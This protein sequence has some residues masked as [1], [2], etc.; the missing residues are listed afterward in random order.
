MSKLKIRAGIKKILRILLF[1]ATGVILLLGICYTLLQS[2][3]V[4]TS[5]VKYITQ[6]VEESTG[7]RIQI[8][9]VDF[10]P[11]RSLVLNDVLLKDFK[12]DTLIYCQNLR[13]HADSFNLVNRSFVVSEIILDK[14]CFYLWISRGEEDSKTN[15]EVFL[16][17]LRGRNT[18]IEGKEQNLQ[19]EKGWLVGLKKVGIRNSHF[20][21]KEEEYKPVNYGV[22]WTDVD[23]RELNADLAGFHFDEGSVGLVVSG[24]SFV[25]KSGLRM[26]D[27]NGRVSIGGDNLVI[28]D[29]RI[30]LERSKVD[31]MKLEF[32]W[33]PKQ[34][35]WRH[36]TTRMQQYYELGPSAVSFVDLAYFNEILRGIDNTVKCSGIVSNTI[37]Q[38]EG[39][40][41]YFELGERTIFQGSF[42]SQGLPDVWNTFF[43]IELYKAHLGPK[44]LAGIYL[45]WFGMNIPVPHFLYRLPYL[46]FEQISFHGTL[47][48]FMVKAKSITPALAGSLN[49]MYGPCAGGVSDCVG[50]KGDF[51]FRRVNFGKLTGFSW[52]G[53]G[54]LTGN[55]AGTWADRGPSFRMNAQLQR[56]NVNQGVVKGTDIAMTWE[57]SK[58]DL[59]AAV[60]NELVNGGVVVRY[61]DNDSLDFISCRGQLA[62]NDL[63]AFGIGMKK[64]EQEK[65][66]VTFDFVQAQQQ[67]KRFINLTLSDLYYEN[68]SGGF[69]LENL[70]L[71][72]SRYGDYN[73]TTLKSDIVDLA[74]EGKF[75]MI[76]PIPFVVQLLQTYLPAYTKYYT[77]QRLWKNRLEQ[78]EFKYTVDV[79]NLNPVLRVLCPE[80]SISPGTRLESCFRH[81]DEELNLNLWSDSIRYQNIHL[82]NSVMNLKGNRERLKATYHA[83]QVRYGNDYQLYNVC[84]E[85]RLADNRVDNRLSWSNWTDKTYCGELSA[86]VLFTPEGKNGYR[87]DIQIEPGVIVMDDS[88]WRV[89]KSSVMIKGKEVEIQDFSVR[90][91]K[92]FLFVGG[93]ISE[94]PEDKL[95]INLESFNLRNLSRIALNSRSDV[96][97]TATGSLVVQDYYKDCLLISDFTVDNW[98]IKRD[99]LGSLHWRSYWDM[100]SKS[101]IV[102]AENRVGT[103]VPLVISGYYT[104]ASDTLSV[105]LRLDRIGL[106]RVGRYVSDYFSDT[107]GYLSGN[108]DIAGPLRKP[109]FSGFVYLDSVGLKVNALN[110]DFYVHDSI[111]MVRNKLFLKDFSLWDRRGKRAVLEGEYR[112][113]EKRYSLN[114][115]FNEFQVLNTRM[116]DNEL[117]YGQM[118]LSGL[119]EMNN[120]GGQMNVTVNARTENESK[121]Y[122]P[123]AAGMTE[124]A[125]NFLHFTTTDRAEEHKFQVK[126]ALAD[127]N[128]NANLEVNDHLNVQVIFDPTVGDILRTTG[129]GDIKIAFDKEGSLSLF[130]EYRISRGDYLF[131]LSNLV[132]KKFVLTPGGT[133]VWS[134]SPY[135]AM[136]DINAVYNLRTTITELLPQERSGADETGEERIATETG[137]KVPVECILNLSDNLKNPVVKFDI[138]FPTLETQSKSYVQ[139]L[140]LS[141][142]ELNKQVFS[143][144]VLNRFY[145]T[146]NTGDYENQAQV[147]GVT[148]LTEMMS[149]QLSRWFSQFSNNVDIGVA[150]RRGDREK[151]MTSDELELAV[152]TQLL[153]DRITISANGNMDV[154]GNKGTAEENK[155]TNIAGDFDVEVKLNKQGTLKMKAY[156]HTDEK[157]LYNSTETIQGVGVSYQESFDTFREL[158]HKY[159]GFLT[160]KK[161]KSGKKKVTEDITKNN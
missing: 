149:N 123:L 72:D 130:G 51:K 128:L 65:A 53:N 148:T 64:E 60:E 112:I 27:L 75:R 25:E 147:A 77:K 155:K 5:L 108:V 30:E 90:R 96:F 137:R 153:D 117:F 18:G 127:I 142:D 139:S 111:F 129:D 66:G 150:Y 35:D 13:V 41:L 76:R 113:W 1:I 3:C 69:Q 9:S 78:F 22:N 93:K 74:M 115:R 82:I 95:F 20:T 73:T 44:D 24:L 85:L 8:G 151:E 56:L 154:G 61:E 26:Q 14:A 7:V 59:L 101:V 4:Q 88:V 106:E 87:A 92:E 97:G 86:S 15:I 98:G 141:Q 104:P 81:G 29:C 70:S 100:E 79:K 159:F 156:S 136:L 11:V 144:L 125:N 126:N 48:D 160:K 116:V 134:G 36:F 34:H 16:D 89:N 67:A 140:F 33:V 124:H 2:S 99:T 161:S 94:R 63:A 138:D 158:L 57:D 32:K 114:A 110:T 21:Y 121:L 68:S 109:D 102:G 31:L 84:D 91:G 131:T 23:C 39:H 47:A 105:N 52:L 40:D 157:I 145:R 71:E 6:R 46:D 152:S 19:Q 103:E 49:F 10:R 28:T 133:I 54:V 118:Y 42:K 43:D 58:V 45:P 80:F 55:Y 83:E 38:L 37:H 12:N 132:N 50:M 119:A 122:L 120:A 135:D 146:D 107:R 143:L 62:L 17:S